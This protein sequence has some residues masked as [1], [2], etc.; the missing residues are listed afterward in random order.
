M[1]V[2]VDIDGWMCLHFAALNGNIYTL[3]TLLEYIN[4]SYIPSTVM[5]LVNQKTNEGVTALLYACEGK[6]SA[7]VKVLLA[8][9]A[10][11]TMEGTQ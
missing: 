11:A 2:F 9:G 6:H 1:V 8:N 7:A 10:D 5:N 4:D 3:E